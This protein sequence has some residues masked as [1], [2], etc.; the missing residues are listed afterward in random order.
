MLRAF[1]C[2]LLGLGAWGIPALAIAQESFSL[3]GRVSDRQGGVV[4]GATVLLT[5][6]SGPA[7]TTQSS[8]G[9]TF[10]FE[11]LRRAEYTLQVNSPGFAAW[12]QVLQLVAGQTELMVTLDI[13]GLSETVG[14]VGTGVSPLVVPAPTASRLGITPLETP[15]SLSIVTGDTI[16]QRADVTIEDAETRIVGITSQGAPGNGGTSRFSRGFG[17][18]NSLMKLYDGVQLFVAAGTLTFPF[19]TWNVE[20]IEFLGGPASVMYGNGAIG[21][22]V[23][24]VPKRPNRFTTENALRIGAGSQDTMRAAFGRGGP[25]NDRVAYRV[26]V[27][28]NTSDGYVERGDS[29]STALSGSMSFAVTPRLDITVSEDFGYQKPMEYFGSI[30]VDGQLNEALRHVNY[31][32]SDADIHYKDSWTQFKTEWR[33]GRNI[34]VRNNFNVLTSNRFWHDVETY[35]YVPATGLVNRTS[36]IEIF[37][38]QLQFGEHAEA[39]ISTSLGGR[40]NTTAFGFD[41][42]WTRF[43]YTNNSPYSG[44]SVVPIT[45]PNPGLFLNVPGTRPDFNAHQDQVA[46]FVEDRF[47]INARWSAIAGARMDHYSVKRDALRLGTTASREFTPVNWRGGLVY[48]LQPGFSLYGQYVTATDGVGQLLTLSPEQQ[49]FDLT[50]GRQ[51]EGGAKQSLANGRGEWTAAVYQIVKKKLLVPDPNNPVLRQ[52]I[53]QQSSKGVE[54]TGSLNV[55]AG[56]RVDA[57]VAMLDARYDDFTELSAGVLTSWA[58]N[59]PTNIPERVGSLWLAWKLPQRFLV[60]GGLRYMGSRYLNNA[61]TVTTDGATVIDVN[62]RR[63]LTDRVSVDLRAT[64]LF[65]KFYLQSVSGAPIPLRGRIGPPRAV[66]LMFNARF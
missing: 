31:N 40:T 34:V 49:L 54:L 43:E 23:N 26:D 17:G 27:S 12:S 42:S 64:N 47:V 62:V 29:Q 46:L 52:Q 22:V 58:G 41:Y 6:P 57:N 36:Y 25:I 50:P 48:A 53:G 61:N 20:R 38:D 51:I 33:P 59:T 1:S 19:D 55:G 60:Q 56:L 13:A 11:G 39:T 32:V 44:S 28:H 4:V 14:V 10:N 3:R 5:P 65:D 37:H 35:A 63:N 2:V 30:L 16:R 45:N 9:G 18:L 21:G 24:V 7:Q 8:A 66:E 15:A